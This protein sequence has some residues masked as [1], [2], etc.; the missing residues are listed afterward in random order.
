MTHRRVRVIVAAL[1]GWLPAAAAAGAPTDAGPTGTAKAPTPVRWEDACAREAPR[2]CPGVPAGRRRA[3]L[4]QREDD[5]TDGCWRALVRRSRFGQV[6]F[7]DLNRFCKAGP[8]RIPACLQEHAND[9]NPACRAHINGERV[10][11]D[12]TVVRGKPADQKGGSR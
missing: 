6:C 8:T 3:C 10:R 1:L 5:L 4:Y 7:G 9:L 11:A 12:G 2:V